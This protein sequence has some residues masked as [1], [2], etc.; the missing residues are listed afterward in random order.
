MLTIIIFCQI[1]DFCK[2]HFENIEKEWILKGKLNAAEIITICILY[3][4][5]GYKTFKHYYINKVL[6]EMKIDF[7]NLASYTRFLELKN[8]HRDLTKTIFS[9]LYQNKATDIS[10][11]D[12]SSIKVCHIN[13][14]HANKVFKNKAKKGYSMKGSFYGFKLHLIINNR[15]EIINAKITSGNIADNNH[16][17]LTDLTQNISGKIYGD[18]GYMVNKD[19]Y[20]NLLEKDITIITKKRNN[21]KNYSDISAFD[22]QLLKKRSIIETIFGILKETFSMEHSRHRS[23]DGFFMHIFSSLFAYSFKE[24]KPIF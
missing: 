1:Y 6:K 4:Y 7:P 20:N 19:F 2:S 15:A 10:Y 3:H 11:I 12:S 14:M 17:L 13:R 5:S 8:E 9:N 21:M 23:V 22:Q 16:N 24:K 18:K